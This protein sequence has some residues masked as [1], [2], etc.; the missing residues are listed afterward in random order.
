VIRC[1]YLMEQ[2]LCGQRPHTPQHFF[3]SWRINFI[4]KVVLTEGV[5]TL[6]IEFSTDRYLTAGFF[7]P[8]VTAR[9]TAV[10][11]ATVRVR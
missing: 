2:S 6:K 4:L 11:A 3:G 9:Y 8:S 7:L 5:D 10:T 1:W